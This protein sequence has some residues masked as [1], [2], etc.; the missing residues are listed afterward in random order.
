MSENLPRRKVENPR[1]NLFDFN[2]IDPL[3]EWINNKVELDEKLSRH[4][5]RKILWIMLLITLYIF[6]QH[7]FDGL[8]RKLNKTSRDVNEARA[9]Y[10]SYKS[11]YMFASKQ[12]EVEKKLAG[13][14][15]D[16]NGQPP[17]KIV[18]AN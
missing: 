10:I 9:A 1:A 18:I 5:L 4:T 8:I 6:F 17:I 2:V 13:R 14:G 12:S 3:A 16:Q 11:K 7:N 15:F